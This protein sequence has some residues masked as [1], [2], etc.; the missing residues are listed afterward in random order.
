MSSMFFYAGYNATTW[1]IAI[2]KTNNGTTT[3]SIENTTS[4][5]Y[6]KTTSYYVSPSSGR[7]FTLAN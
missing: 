1:S 2:P 7:S 3:G 6:G 5:L 4:R